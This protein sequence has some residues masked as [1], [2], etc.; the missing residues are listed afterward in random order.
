MVERR[1]KRIKEKRRQIALTIKLNIL[2]RN[3]KRKR[4]KGPMPVSFSPFSF[5]VL[6]KN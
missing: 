5:N 2:V 1:A 3:K 6:A 4:D